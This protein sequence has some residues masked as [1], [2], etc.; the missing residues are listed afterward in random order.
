M[1]NI[2]QDAT[3]LPSDW[4]DIHNLWQDM[5][6]FAQDNPRHIFHCADDPGLNHLPRRISRIGWVAYLETA[7]ISESFRIADEQTH[8]WT[9]TIPYF[10]T[11]LKNMYFQDKELHSFYQR[12]IISPKSATNTNFRQ[13]A[14]S[15]LRNNL[16]PD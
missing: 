3:P 15:F 4:Y 12:M 7:K 2:E 11:S 6:R 10:L 16:Q 13:A 1:T 9:I 8:V 14:L 5:K